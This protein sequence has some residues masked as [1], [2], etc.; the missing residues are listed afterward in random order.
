M[1]GEGSEASNDQGDDKRERNE[2]ETYALRDI[3]R[4]VPFGCDLW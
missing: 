3:Y 1:L 4:N 2:Y